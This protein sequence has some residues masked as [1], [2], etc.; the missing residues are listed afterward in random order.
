M[1]PETS[2]ERLG[3]W[4]DLLEED[5]REAFD[6]WAAALG[7]GEKIDL[8]VLLNFE[9]ERRIPADVG[10]EFIEEVLGRFTDGI[11]ARA[12]VSA[13]FTAHRRRY[14]SAPSDDPWSGILTIGPE[15]EG[16][17]PP[18]G[19]RFL[20]STAIR[21]AR[22]FD[23]PFEEDQPLP[24]RLRLKRCARE[25]APWF[26]C[27]FDHG[28]AQESL[29][30]LTATKARSGLGLAHVP[31]GDFLY[32]TTVALRPLD[33]LRVPSLLDTGGEPP[34]RPV[35]AAEYPNFGWTRDLDTGERGFPEVLKSDG[36]ELDQRVWADVVRGANGLP[37]G[38]EIPSEAAR[39]QYLDAISI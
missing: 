34:W 35:D 14:S 32:R 6:R 12:A 18:E 22:L 13:A 3:H 31:A 27:A 30:A 7:Q 8:A 21:D 37:E 17:I 36:Q 39:N 20:P 1:P 28:E 23:T 11:S 24:P 38:I 15:A 16:P 26:F 5:L 33:H 2:S 4:R 29:D 25:G 9:E 10:R 19:R